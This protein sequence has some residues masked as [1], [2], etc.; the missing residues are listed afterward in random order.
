MSEFID[1]FRNL[2][3]GEALALNRA[4]RQAEQKL[5]GESGG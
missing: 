3:V 4:V 2:T 1:K 5:K